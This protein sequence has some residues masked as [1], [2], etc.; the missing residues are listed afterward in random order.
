MTTAC[1]IV[2][3]GAGIAG[4]SVACELALDNN[5]CLLEREAQPG[6][7]STGR[8]AALF[9]EAYGP[10]VIRRLTAASRAFYKN[11]PAGFT[12]TS[13]LQPRGALVVA[14][15]GQ[16]DL[17]TRAAG[18]AAGTAI[19]LQHWTPQQVCERV[20]VIRREGL[21][22][23]LYEPGAEDIDVHAL[24]QGYLRLFKKRGGRL[25]CNAEVSAIERKKGRWQVTAASGQLFSAGTLVNAAGAWCDEIADMA[26]VSKI[27]LT[28]KR[29]TAFIIAA[30]EQ[31]DV[32]AWP[33]VLGAADDCYFKPEAGK[34]LASPADATP[35]APQDIQ[36]EE[37]DVAV[38][39]DRI[40]AITTMLVERVERAWAGL[41]SFV[42]D[43]TPV[44]GYAPDTEDF[45]WLA[46]QGG[47]GIQTAPA[48][49][50]LAGCILHGRKLPDVLLKHGVDP[51]ALSAER[52]QYVCA[53]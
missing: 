46:G 26:G 6:Y 16:E 24:H 45:F 29:R 23:G 12:E 38:A 33:L 30:P 13:L 2:V 34:L 25:F 48:M 31:Y 20:P 7:H 1:D 52:L 53:Q 51:A 21:I 44:V 14:V 49:G 17:I 28:P 32:S 47:Y 40:E 41:R 50:V 39:V 15:S 43:G 22:G 3:V 18:Q 5:I 4:A 27:G 19:E 35:V 8:S 11:P 9:T 37:Y 36:P 10:S 42:A